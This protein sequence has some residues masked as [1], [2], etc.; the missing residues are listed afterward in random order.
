M[1]EPLENLRTAV[2][3][4]C[5]ISDARHAGDYT[6]CVYLLK[7]REYYR[8]EQ[9]LPFTAQLPNHDVG[10]WLAEREALW[11]D[12]ADQAFTSLPIDDRHFD[13]FHT[14]DINDAL[15]PRGL[16][17]SGGLGNSCRPHFFLAELERHESQDEHSVLVAG[18]EL[19]RDLTAP[20]AMTL[21][22][23]IFVR[24]ESLR[25]M[26]W[27]KV[28]EWKWR[29]QDGALSRALAHYDFDADVPAALEA[30]TDVEVDSVI[31][32]E[33]GEIQA[34]QRL[35]ESWHEM[36]A[37]LPPSQAE[38]MA[39]AVRDHLADCLT[40]LPALIDEQQPAS[41]HF[42]FGNLRGMRKEIFPAAQRAYEQW[43]EHGRLEPLEEIAAQG[44]RHWTDVARNVLGLFQE[45]GPESTVHIEQFVRSNPL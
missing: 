7:M 22:R 23:T 16:V 13:P 14:Q 19:A 31:R 10:T 34:G 17:Y 24:R 42:Y 44:T 20:P 15:L 25:R 21:D 35:G 2:Q 33:I 11:E 29:R 8:W 36:L 39:R 27:E 12:L 28:E 9:N 3:T 43:A 32:H 6:L 30:I 38:L 45:H 26:I 41:L 40:T 37:G 1:T 4:N 5:H 18:R